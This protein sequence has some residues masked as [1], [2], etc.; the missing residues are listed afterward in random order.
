MLKCYKCLCE[1]SQD[2]LEALT[3]L[4]TPPQL[5]TC[6]NCA[7]KEFKRGIWL[8]E[9]GNS[10]LVIASKIYHNRMIREDINQ[11]VKETEI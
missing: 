10:E 8:G 1:I 2:R 5:L 7:P 4:E 3:V 6:I 9:S 11:Y